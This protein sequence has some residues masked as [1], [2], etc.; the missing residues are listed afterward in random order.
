M[1]FVVRKPSPFSTDA[2]AQNYQRASARTQSVPV[3]T[4]GQ[5]LIERNGR[6]LLRLTNQILDF[7]RLE[8]GQMP[9]KLV[10]TDLIPFI[11]YVGESFH[12]KNAYFMTR[13]LLVQ[14][15]PNKSP[16]HTVL[17]LYPYSLHPNIC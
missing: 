17:P 3:E 5:V 11:H 12:F 4:P 2:K 8:T 6:N 14:R 10:R 9:L 16:N 7:F 1:N 13:L 15:S